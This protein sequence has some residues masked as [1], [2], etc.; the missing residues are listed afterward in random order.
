MLSSTPK[1]DFPIFQTI[2]IKSAYYILET[3]FRSTNDDD[4]AL[5]RLI[6]VQMNL[7]FLSLMTLL[8]V[9][10][11][12]FTWSL[13][14]VIVCNCCMNTVQDVKSEKELREKCLIK[15]CMLS[16]AAFSG[17]DLEDIT[18]WREDMNIIFE[19]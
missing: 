18:R 8:A 11:F 14:F 5:A 15:G 7:K 12:F 10:T 2:W 3:Q 9:V 16:I 19:W 4:E 6:A 1:F 13:L 17:N